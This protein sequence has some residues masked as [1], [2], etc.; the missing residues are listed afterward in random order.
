MQYTGARILIEALIEQ[1]VDTVFG[2]PG[3]AVLFIYDELY[4]HQDRIRHILVSHEQHAAHAAD[5]YARSTGKVGVCLATS[6]PGAT[7]LITGIATAH[8]DSVPMVAITGNVATNLLGKDSFQEVDITGISMPVVKHNWI[9]KDVNALAETVREAFIVAQSGRPGP[10]LIDIPKDITAIPGEWIPLRSGAKVKNIQSIS[11]NKLVAG[12]IPEGADQSEITAEEEILSARARRL[13]ER[14]RRTTFTDEDLDRAVKFFREAKRPVIYAGGGVISSDACGELTE[15]AER[16]NAPVA[17]SLMGIGAF[18][19]E[20]RLYTGLIGMHGTVASNKA[21]QKADLLITLGARFSDR[22]TSRADKFAQSA[23]ILHID[24]D[25]AEVNKNV[26]AHAWII[27]DIKLILTK[28][29]KKIPQHLKTDWQGDIEKWKEKIPKAH[30]PGGSKLHPRLIIEETAKRLGYDAIV[31]TDVGQHQIW[32]AQFY[33]FTRPRSFI[34]SGGL[35][36]MGFGLGAIMGAKVA[37][38]KRPAV[39]FTGDGSFRMNCGE[40]GTIS[41]YKIPILIVIINNQVLG[42][43]R[44]W[45]SLFY[46]E[47]YS[48]T[49]L[50]RPPDFV[51]LAEAY[52]LKGYRAENEKTFIEALDNAMKDIASGLTALIDAQINRDE[53]VLPMVPGGKPIDEQ[54]L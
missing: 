48:E 33:P 26:G 12:I 44:Q 37:N 9:V 5:G 1:G 53:Q 8:M 47:R 30:H 50:D 16:L 29:L 7:N 17:L 49:I 14:N 3:G 28:L 39:L 34:T 27:G 23:R 38:P 24:I 40:M 11:A 52:G 4:K 51:K 46:E 43:V 42:M 15:F 31:A 22:V 20:H 54:I 35:G 10:V 19:R 36:T 25:P 41:N 32:T 13:T 6:G 2:Y 18:P 21:V 45:Q